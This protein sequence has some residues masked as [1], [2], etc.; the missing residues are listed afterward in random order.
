V[1]KRES[2][3]QRYGRGLPNFMEDAVR[4][5][6]DFMEDTSKNRQFLVIISFIKLMLLKIRVRK[7]KF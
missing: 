2:R 4:E 3:G 7:V 1:H 6:E 5:L